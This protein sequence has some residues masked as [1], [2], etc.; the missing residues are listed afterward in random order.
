MLKLRLNLSVH[1]ATLKL[2]WAFTQCVCVAV[3]HQDCG[4]CILLQLCCWELL[5]VLWTDNASICHLPAIVIVCQIRF[6]AFKQWVNLTHTS[7][8]ING[9]FDFSSVRKRKTHDRICANDWTVFY[10]H[11]AMYKNPPPKLDMPTYSVHVDRSVHVS[12]CSTQHVAVLKASAS[13]YQ[14]SQL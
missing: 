1:P 4:E 11:R 13:T 14:S 7:T 3:M 6:I 10:N 8:Y 2:C 12:Y 5:V 9:P